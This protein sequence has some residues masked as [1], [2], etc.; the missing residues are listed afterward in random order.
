MSH[1][2]TKHINKYLYIALLSIVLIVIFTMLQV[3]LI[4]SGNGLDMG[5]Q[6]VIISSLSI[7]NNIFSA[8]APMSL[9]AYLVL[10]DLRSN[11]NKID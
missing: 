5:S 7:L 4:S 9:V 8:L 10:I 1:W 6:T 11:Q 3:L 2:A